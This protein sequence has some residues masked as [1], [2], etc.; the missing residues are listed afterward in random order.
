MFRF[1]LIISGLLCI[2]FL[3]YGSAQKLDVLKSLYHECQS[4]AEKFDYHKEYKYSEE[5]LKLSR[6][7]KNK[8][9]EARALL[10]YGTS[11]LFTGRSETAQ[12]DLLNGL[13]LSKELRN[14]S[15]IALAYNSLAIYEGMVNSNLNISQNYL[16]KARDYALKSNYENLIT[17]IYNN[18][19]EI[20]IK[21]EDPN[22]L[23][24]AILQYRQGKSGK[25]PRMMFL[26]AD[27][28]A[29]FNYLSK[30]FD[31]AREY[32]Q[33]AKTIQ[34]NNGYAHNGNLNYTAA[35]IDIESGHL[36]NAETNAHL[37]IEDS[38][39]LAAE[40]QA[41]AL[42]LLAK[43]K[44]LQGLYNQ[45]NQLLME[46]AKLI[47]GND[48]KNIEEKLE[49]L[50]ASNFEA[51]G[52]SINALNAL[53]KADSLANVVNS[54]EKQHLINER[55]MMLEIYDHETNA[56]VLNLQA[57]HQRYIIW[58]LSVGAVI[59]VLF[60]IFMI[61][62]IRKRNFLYRH[63]VSNYKEILNFEKESRQSESIESDIEDA[64]GKELK[65]DTENDKPA[66]SSFLDNEKS[67]K[68]YSRLCELLEKER[69]YTDPNFT[70][71]ELVE[72]LQTNRTYLSQII[73][74]HT[75]KNYSQLINSYR[76]KDAIKILSDPGKKEYPLKKISDELGFVSSNTFSKVFQ[77]TVGM[78][79]SYFRK[80]S[81]E[82]VG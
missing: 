32:I 23:D 65:S 31:K 82:Q 58:S 26:G 78:S 73:K 36:K 30:N 38:Q 21:Q 4:A 10:F 7:S 2:H 56:K 1:I 75:G 66:K 52:E 35:L 24:Y 69:L 68:I 60:L 67:K 13:Q 25:N 3:A 49:R 43:I 50:K 46:V 12:Q 34:K 62:S 77:Q 76:I 9:Y 19:S 55:S 71:E 64:S 37:F 22:G 28:L 61:F 74:I 16:L 8:D 11:K 45:S 72:R 80:T 39:K 63:I 53:T 48:L 41:D 44:N 81:F 54:L 40:D 17:S 20:A 79:P 6:D 57:K 42:I 47:K 27:N 51:L 15:L 70:R 5:L 14:D 59:L 29:Y 33:I 18:L